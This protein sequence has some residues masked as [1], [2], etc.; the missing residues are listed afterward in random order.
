[1]LRVWTYALTIGFHKKTNEGIGDILLPPLFR[2]IRNEQSANA[3]VKIRQVR[4][5][6]LRSIQQSLT[7]PRLCLERRIRPE[8]PENRYELRV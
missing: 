2:S 3:D 6:L 8:P 4:S 7:M 5:L 1:M